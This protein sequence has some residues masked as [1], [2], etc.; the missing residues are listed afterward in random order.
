MIGKYILFE[1]RSQY[2]MGCMNNL[3]FTYITGYIVAI[4]IAISLMKSGKLIRMV[5]YLDYDLAPLI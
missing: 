1:C 2:Y 4:K 3:L 5:M